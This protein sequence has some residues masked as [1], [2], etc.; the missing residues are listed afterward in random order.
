[1]APLPPILSDFTRSGDGLTG[2]VQVGQVESSDF[3]LIAGVGLAPPP[4][5]NPIAVVGG[6]T[7]SGICAL[8][9]GPLAG[10]P[11]VLVA[12]VGIPPGEAAL[13]ETA[14]GPL[15]GIQPRIL[16]RCAPEIVRR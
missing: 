12:I 16:A 1:M 10:T 7:G 13:A 11:V 4:E 3:C 15:P 9:L 5:A 2:S 8:S 6:I 14:P